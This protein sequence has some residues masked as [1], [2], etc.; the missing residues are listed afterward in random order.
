MCWAKRE[1]PGTVSVW[2]VH[3][4]HGLIP[5]TQNLCGHKNAN[6]PLKSDAGI[7]C[8]KGFIDEDQLLIA[9]ESR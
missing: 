1:N 7:R 3:G 4:H 5:M 2:R 6:A 8:A 9:P